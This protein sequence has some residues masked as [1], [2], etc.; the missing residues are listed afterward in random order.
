MRKL[1]YG[2]KVPFAQMIVWGKRSEYFALAPSLLNGGNALANQNKTLTAS[3]IKY[4]LVMKELSCDRNGVRSTDI[5]KRLEI[6]K[7][8]VYT[9]LK[10]LQGLNLIQKDRY[11]V[12]YFT[13]QGFETAEKYLSYF[14]TIQTYLDALLPKNS[15]VKSATYALLSEIPEDAIEEMCNRLKKESGDEK[16]TP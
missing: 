4:L 11:S 12:I 5:A 13:E 8:S 6:T 9:L 3:N 14:E 2:R 7:P 15:D 16:H 10:T 1:P